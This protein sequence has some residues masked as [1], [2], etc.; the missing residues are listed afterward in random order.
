MALAAAST[1]GFCGSPQAVL[2]GSLQLG[3]LSSGRLSM[4]KANRMPFAGP[5]GL[6]VRAEQQ[7]SLA[8]SAATSRRAMLGLV[9]AG[10]AS[11]SLVQ[12]VLA[13]TKAPLV[14]TPGAFSGIPKP[15][16]IAGIAGSISQSAISKQLIHYAIK[17]AESIP[18]LEV[19]YIDIDSLPLFNLDLVRH[20]KYPDVV[21]TFMDQVHA[22]DG[23]LFASPEYNYTVSSPL[24]NAIDWASMEPTVLGDK[25]AAIVSTGWDLGGS[26]SQYLRQI[27]IRPDVYFIN[28]PELFINV[29]RKVFD[30]NGNIT[31]SDIEKEFRELLISLRNFTNRLRPCPRI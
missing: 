10:I 15:V 2:Q 31:D 24:K 3:D 22:T 27:G 16:K 17:L 14:G 13:E 7:Q 29:K 12:T 30:D 5:G 26:R 25:T 23:I 20:G 19:E 6:A 8:E 1:A 21:Q 9:A 18:G 11:G 4:A 28:K